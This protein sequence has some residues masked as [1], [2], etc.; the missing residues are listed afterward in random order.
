MYPRLGVAEV[1]LSCLIGLIG[2]GIPVTMLVLLFMIY[3]KLKSIEGALKK[4]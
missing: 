3:N 4:E 1:L 2:V